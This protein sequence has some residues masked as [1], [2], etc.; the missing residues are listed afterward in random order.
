MI[1]P[2]GRVVRDV[3]YN[4]QED[5]YTGDNRSILAENLLKSPIVD[6]AYQQNPTSTVYIVRED[7]ILVTFTF[8]REQ[9]IWAWAEHRSY[10]GEYK[11]VCCVP[12]DGKD[13]VY[14]LV[15]RKFGTNYYKYFL[16]EQVVREFGEDSENS[17]F[18]DCAY[19]YSSETPFTSVSVGALSGLPVSGVADGSAFSIQNTVRG[20]IDLPQP[21]NHI[22]VGLPYEMEVVTVDPDIKGQDGTRFGSIK[23]L[24]QVTFELLE[25]AT[26]HAGADANH[27]EVLKIPT[28][29][30]WGEPVVF[31][32]GKLRSPIPGFARNEASIRFTSDDPFP[33]TVLAVRTEVNVE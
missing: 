6:W 28:T 22:I 3:H 7:G 2:S 24:G 18:V 20:V 14:F 10:N 26:L 23:T 5:G 29:K 17:C 19:E 13:R 27:M 25:T 4:I 31:Y 15:K 1:E 12:E 33:A 21:A 30:Q 32:S 8:M 9:E 16:E 11:S